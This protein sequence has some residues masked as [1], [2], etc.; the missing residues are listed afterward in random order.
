M[1]KT[2]D[3]SGRATQL[4]DV[5]LGTFFRPKTIAVIGASDTPRRPATAMWRKIRVWGEKF[6]ATVT[7]VSPKRT[8]LDGVPC[9]PS[10]ADVP[11]P[12]ALAVILVG[13]AIDMF[14]EVAAA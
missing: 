3:V 13:N 12:V 2:T 8:E 4:R 14:E 7:P 10:I 9:L 5:D 6:G 1:A 11:G